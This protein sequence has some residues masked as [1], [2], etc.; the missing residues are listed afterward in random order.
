MSGVAPEPVGKPLFRSALRRA[1]VLRWPGMKTKPGRN[2][3][4]TCGSG[5][6]FKHCCIDRPLTATLRLIE[7]PGSQARS[8]ELVNFAKFDEVLG[9]EVLAAF[10]RC[11]VHTD[12][13]LSLISFAHISNQTYGEKSTAF[14]R[15]LHTMVWFTIG[16]L[17]ELALAIQGLRAAFA[18]KGILNQDGEPWLK[19]REIEDRWNNDEGF[20]KVRDRAA[21]HVDPEVM[22]LGVHALVKDVR[23]VELFKGDD[24]GQI[25]GSFTLGTTV[26]HNG[27][28]WN[29]E[30][31]G[32]FLEQVSTDHGA[33]IDAVQ[34]VLVEATEAVGID[35]VKK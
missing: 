9:T 7:V 14:G 26:L 11:F 17:R 27:L 8:I 13:L 2:D 28:G 18:K 5:K 32:R 4:C 20:R 10:S 30:D 15:D 25:H 35:V 6:K 23:D 3:V 33:V 19:L 24:E 34:H 1:Q 22:T 21:F 29:L 31:Y 12:R 16:T